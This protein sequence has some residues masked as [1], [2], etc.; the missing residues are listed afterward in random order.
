MSEDEFDSHYPLLKNHLNPIASWVYGEG[1]GCLFETYGEELTFVQQQDPSTVWTLVDGDEGDQYLLRGFH[2]VNRIGYLVSTVAVPESVDIEVRIPMQ[3]ERDDDQAIEALAPPG[4][5]DRL[6]SDI[7]REHL[8]IP[9]LDTRRSDSLDFH[10]VAVWQVESALKAAYIA[11]LKAAGQNTQ[12]Q[13]ARETTPARALPVTPLCI[14]KGTPL[15]PGK[16]YLRLYHGRT[17]PAQEMDAWGFE[18]PTFGPLSCYVHTYCSTF[19][20][21]AECGYHELWLETHGDMIRWDGCYYGD[22]E[23]FIAKADDKA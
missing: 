12:P 16:L 3:A 23:V 7:A 19:R 9:T 4:V 1:P 22:L 15:I 21:H 11:G 6:L 10:D 17:D 2:F 18:G 14:P 13:A 8:G 20:I 5:H